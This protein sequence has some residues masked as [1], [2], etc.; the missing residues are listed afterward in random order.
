MSSYDSINVSNTSTVRGII[1]DALVQS[2]ANFSGVQYLEY[3]MEILNF[4][5]LS[6]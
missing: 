5:P 4:L 2:G 1:L 3:W 6:A